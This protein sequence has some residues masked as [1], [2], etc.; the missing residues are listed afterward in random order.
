MV[1]TTK[2]DDPNVNLYVFMLLLPWVQTFPSIRRLRT[3]S[4]C[5]YGLFD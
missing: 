5:R 4:F 2:C 1:K 3:P